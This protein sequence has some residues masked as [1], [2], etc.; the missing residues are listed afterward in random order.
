[1]AGCGAAVGKRSTYLHAATY[2]SAANAWFRYC[3]LQ[4]CTRLFRLTL[5]EAASVML[6]QSQTKIF[7]PIFFL[8]GIC[9]FLFLLVSVSARLPFS[10]MNPDQHA[11]LSVVLR[12]YVSLASVRNRLP[13]ATKM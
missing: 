3:L 13:I 8:S 7:L 9:P 10:N 4:P 12:F 5:T 2:D 6:N 11:Q 1:M